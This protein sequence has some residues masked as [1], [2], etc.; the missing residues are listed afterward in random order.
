MEALLNQT[1]PLLAK[2]PNHISLEFTDRPVLIISTKY[3]SSTKKI[4]LKND[5]LA[6]LCES[7]QLISLVLSMKQNHIYFRIGNQTYDYRPHRGKL[8]RI[9][10]SE[11]RVAKTDRSELLLNF[12]SVELSNLKKYIVTKVVTVLGGI[13]FLYFLAKA[14]PK[15]F[16]DYKL[17]KKEN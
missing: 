9:A 15:A 3:L 7:P 8:S 17:K 4:N 16:R 10:T 1:R 13:L 11:Y 5:L 6:F 12:D 2:W 14:I